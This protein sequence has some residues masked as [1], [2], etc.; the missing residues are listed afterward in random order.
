MHEPGLRAV[1]SLTMERHSKLKAEATL[2]IGLGYAGVATWATAIP[3]GAL[4]LLRAILATRVLY[5]YLIAVVV[6][7]IV[8]SV[9]STRRAR[10][11]R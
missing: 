5:P 3:L 11:A 4:Y 9:W 7:W 1:V 6:L 8:W 2:I 10:A